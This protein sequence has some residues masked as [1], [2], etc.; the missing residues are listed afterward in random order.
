MAL[1]DSVDYILAVLQWPGIDADK[2]LQ[3]A[4]L[5]IWRSRPHLGF[6]D[7]YLAAAAKEQACGGFPKNARDFRAAGVV[8]PDQLP[9]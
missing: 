1:E 7:A 4:A 6:V 9:S 5:T 3:I 2:H 8:V